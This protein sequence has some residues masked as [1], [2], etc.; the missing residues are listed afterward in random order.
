MHG[1]QARSGMRRLHPVKTKCCATKALFKKVILNR[2]SAWYSLLKLEK[3]DATLCI[4][5]LTSRRRAEQADHTM[6]WR[7]ASKI[8]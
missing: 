5:V 6:A 1:L 3:A 4:S 2:Q 8:D 7:P